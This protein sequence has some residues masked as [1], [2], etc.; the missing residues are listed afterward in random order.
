[1]IGLVMT[2]IVVGCLIRR[3]TKSGKAPPTSLKCLNCPKLV[4]EKR[5]LIV[6]IV[7]LVLLELVTVGGWGWSSMFH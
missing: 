1:M 4:E 6:V 5:Q 3:W 7:G 2:T